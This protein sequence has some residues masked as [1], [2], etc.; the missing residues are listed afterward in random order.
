MFHL[1]FTPH[2]LADYTFNFLYF[3]SKYIIAR[4]DVDDDGNPLLHYHIL[5][6]DDELGVQTLRNAAIANLQ[7]PKSGRG[8]NNRYYAL[9]DDWKDPGYICKYDNIV[10]SKGYTEAQ[11]LD[12]VV[13]GK[14]R[15]LSKVDKSELSGEVAPADFPKKKDKVIK[16]PFQQLVI[17]TASAKWYEYKRECKEAGKKEDKQLIVDYVCE[18]MVQNGKG[19]NQYL[20][21]EL[22]YAILHED[23]DYRE[24]ILRKIKS[25]IFV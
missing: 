17:A 3:Y 5:V 18:A 14:K 8:K 16:V 21:K 13:S 22:T 2:E 9:F 11:I 24:L 20:V 10:G 6:D 12:F 1:R 4:E 15:Y 19:I 25:L 23:L 7:I